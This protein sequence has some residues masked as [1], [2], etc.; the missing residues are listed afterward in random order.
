VSRTILKERQV[1]S[2]KFRKGELKD[3][4]LKYKIGGRVNLFNLY[5]ETM[6]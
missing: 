6:G 5:P 4:C 2:W 3:D 1:E